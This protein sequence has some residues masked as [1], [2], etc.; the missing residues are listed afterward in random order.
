[1]STLSAARAKGE[2]EYIENIFTTHARKLRRK[3]ANIKGQ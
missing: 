2:D 3:K 1:M